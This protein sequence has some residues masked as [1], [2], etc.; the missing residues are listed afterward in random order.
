MKAEVQKPHQPSKFE[1]AVKG[2]KPEKPTQNVIKYE[3][4]KKRD[5]PFR[6]KA[7]NDDERAVR[8]KFNEMHN[9]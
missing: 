9:Q 4:P 2:D 6:E 8:A 5:G 1:L 7:L 3:A